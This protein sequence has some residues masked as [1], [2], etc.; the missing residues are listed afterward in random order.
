MS[1]KEGGRRGAEEG[2]EESGEEDSLVREPE[3]DD[4]GVKE[5]STQTV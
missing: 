4:G 3:R 1:E 5:G 2:E